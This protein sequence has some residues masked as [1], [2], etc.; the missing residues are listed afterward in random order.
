MNGPAI[1][2]STFQIP[3]ISTSIRVTTRVPTGVDWAVVRTEPDRAAPSSMIE[4]LTAWGGSHSVTTK[5]SRV[6]NPRTTIRSRTVEPTAMGP[7]GV[8]C[9][10]SVP[11]PR[12]AVLNG[13]VMNANTSSI[14]RLTSPPH[15]RRMSPILHALAADRGR[16][17][18]R[19]KH[20][21]EEEARDAREGPDEE[22]LES[23][24]DGIAMGP[25]GLHHADSE[26]HSGRGHDR[27]IDRQADGQ[28]EVGEDRR[29]RT[30]TEGNP[31]EGGPLNR[32]P[33]G[34]LD[35]D[36]EFFLD[37]HTQQ[38]FRMAGHHVGHDPG[39]AVRQAVFFEHVNEFGLHCAGPHSALLPLVRDLGQGDLTLALTRQVL[40]GCHTEDPGQRGGNAGDEDREATVR[41]A[42]HGAHHG[43][44]AHQP[45]LRPED[46]FPHVAEEARPSTLLVET[47][48]NAIAIKR[49]CAEPAGRRHVGHPLPPEPLRARAP[50]FRL[51]ASLS[52]DSAR[53]PGTVVSKGLMMDETPSHT[54][55]WT[56]SAGDGGI[57]T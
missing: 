10:E 5:P 18:K 46:R 30:E 26:Q 33:V 15:S 44:G 11:A 22:D 19:G 2:A 6:S 35:R 24:P 38:D 40:A 16:A 20:V 28:Q 56:V 4:P 34:L 41:G 50:H 12:R 7:G 54:R 51:S 23:G 8:T 45:V 9:I 27:P 21:P 31:H 48:P 52:D 1:G 57:V 42:A 14:G 25:A 3:R 47:N 29:E 37:L 13:S 55:V 49:F 53:A 39:L 43:E 17:E 36:P 32:G